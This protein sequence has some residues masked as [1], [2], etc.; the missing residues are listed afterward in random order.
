V[1][2]P[3][4][5][6]G[7]TRDPGDD[8]LVA[9]AQA[10]NV[11]HLVSGDKDLTSLTAASPPVLSPAAFLDLLGPPPPEDWSRVETSPA[12]RC[13]GDRELASEVVVRSS[14]CFAPR[15]LGQAQRD[16]QPPQGRPGGLNRGLAVAH[17]AP[18]DYD[19]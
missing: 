6:E 13:R 4:I 12:C 3:V 1:E 10:A 7:V 19:P 16:R 2:N 17:L 11:D 15:V 18:L 14:T 8:Y 5:A 9:L